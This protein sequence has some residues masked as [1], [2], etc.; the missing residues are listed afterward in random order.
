[1]ITNVNNNKVNAI[2]KTELN[3]DS[4]SSISNIIK[5]TQPVFAFGLRTR[6]VSGEVHCW[7][8]ISMG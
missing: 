3:F 4:N 1:M 2:I 8:D 5:D 7:Y 6:I